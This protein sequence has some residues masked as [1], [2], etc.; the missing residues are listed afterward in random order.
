[1]L[2]IGK[3]T[4]IANGVREA[5]EKSRDCALSDVYGSYSCNK[6]RAMTY[7]LDLMAQLNGHDLRIVSHNTMV[8]SVAFVFE[9]KDTGVCQMAYITRDYDRYFEL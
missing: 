4:K 2:K 5:W 8:F 1:M 7:C 6:A 9:D 3:N